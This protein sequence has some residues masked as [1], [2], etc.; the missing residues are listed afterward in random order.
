MKESFYI[1]FLYETA[2]GRCFLKLLIQPGFSR[3]TASY[4]NSPASRWM[5]PL[6][7]K[8]Y[9]IP[10]ESCESQ[11][12]TS[13]NKFFTR[14]RN[15]QQQDIEQAD[16]KLI[17]PC[18]G[19]LSVYPIQPDITFR[20]KNICYSIE[21]LLQNQKLAAEYQDGTC[22]IFRLAP[23]NYHRYCYI[24]NGLAVKQA[25][26]PGILHCVRPIALNT[27]PVYIQNSR[28]YTIINTKNFDTVVQMEI[29]A[30]IVGKIHNHNHHIYT[31]RGAE[32][33]YFEFGGSTIIILLKSGIIQME[34]RIIENMKKGIETTVKY[35]EYIAVRQH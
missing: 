10:S 4:L 2:L 7:V 21:Q 24:D 30:L 23:H 28:E 6:Y 33:G 1:R 34:K 20:I 3:M 15:I 11:N 13:F 17:S 32:K 35:G 5:V 9:H 27:Y 14:K 22:L 12:Y 29:G 25:S 31:E 19:F 8:K 26:I 16:F 18:D